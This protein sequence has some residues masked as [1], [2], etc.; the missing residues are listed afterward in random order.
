MLRLDTDSLQL[1][2]VHVGTAYE[3]VRKYV[4][5]HDGK[6]VSL[7]LLLDIGR[8][9]SAHA[10]KDAVAEVV[11]EVRRPGAR[12]APQRCAVIGFDPQLQF[13]VMEH[14]HWDITLYDC[15]FRHRQVRVGARTEGCGR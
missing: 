8:F 15:M 4:G 13:V 1:R 11:A 5:V 12:R 3:D 2:E 10:R 9:E 6:S 7:V 14:E